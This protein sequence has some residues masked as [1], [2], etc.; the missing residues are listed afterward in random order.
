MMFLGGRL[1]Y[2]KGVIVKVA[3]YY[4]LYG[5]R[6]TL[7]RSLAKMT[8]LLGGPPEMNMAFLLRDMI[9]SQCLDSSA[10][11]ARPSSGCPDFAWLF[12]HFPDL[13]W[14]RGSRATSNRNGY[15]NIL[16]IS[17]DASRT[18]A[19]LALLGA[20]QELAKNPD[21][22]C[23]ILLWSGGPLEKDFPEVAPT[24][25]LSTLGIGLSEM[26]VLRY[27]LAS[28]RVY[29]NRCLAICNTAVR[30]EANEVCAEAGIPVLAWVHELPSE[31]DTFLGGD[32]CI[33]R[34]DSSSRR[35]VVPAKFVKKALFS[36]YSLCP[37]K[38]SVLYNGMSKQFDKWDR[39]QARRHIRIELGLPEDS[40][41]VLACGAVI[42]RKGPDLFTRVAIETLVSRRLENTYF[43]WLGQ[44]DE[45]LVSRCYADASKHGVIDRVLF[46]GERED[47]DPYFAG[48]DVFVL[49]SRSD[50]CPL[51]V[52]EA[53]G[54][55]LPV[56]AFEG[57]GGGPEI[58]PAGQGFSVP[59]LDTRAMT[60]EVVKL[61]TRPK[62][63][64]RLQTNIQVPEKPTWSRFA[65]SL[66]RILSQ[67]YDYHPS[68][69]IQV[70]VI[71]PS[72]NHE[73]YLEQR[74][75][76]IFNQTHPPTEIILA[77]D[78]STDESVALAKR[79][80]AT[81]RIPF[82]VVMSY[83]H[84]GRP[85]EQWLAGIAESCGNVIWIAESDDF[86]DSDFLETVLPE[87]FDPD[88]SLAYCQSA[89][90]DEEGYL[91]DRSY[92]AYTDDIS[93]TRWLTYH[94]AD[95]LHEIE[96]V[97]SVKNTIPNVSGVLFRRLDRTPFCE[98]L[99]GFQ[100]CGDWFFY[101]N[102]LQT[103]SVSFIPRPLNRH[104]KH[105]HSVTSAFDGTDSGSQEKNRIKNHIS[106]LVAQY[107][108]KGP[109]EEQ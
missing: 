109:H 41:V 80:A 63:E 98:D 90:V 85:F 101:V 13:P 72:Y 39:L 108:R 35:I 6:A 11:Q 30:S 44:R 93:T 55:G 40:Y 5:P 58:F 2:V 47:P 57:A 69:P 107:R 97:L 48:A 49:T 24:L 10:F 75:N 73:R 68:L 84:S 29:A 20:V 100:W 45:Y 92:L 81:S 74:L 9:N 46:V 70:S 26:D 16:I 103:G 51:V 53:L 21:F 76:S 59:Y 66:V 61:L 87:F 33:G 64:E 56:I 34:I 99:K 52:G 38:I 7:K 106:A 43:V 83:A 91:I 19:P 28:F 15:F 71:V 67:E 82:R 8:G 37:D 65:E 32:K 94:R 102:Q 36:R 96:N 86:C 18:G 3:R 4:R 27:V 42:D 1:V 104:R 17:H 95:G 12:R 54:F 31:I 77:D 22:Q 25:N 79:I 14:N 88:V 89:P 50:S 23:W 78:A 105:G 60:S 62:I